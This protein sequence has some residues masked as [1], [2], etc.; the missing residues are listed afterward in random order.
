MSQNNE[1]LYSAEIQLR[2]RYSETDQMGYCYYGNYAQYF[3][4]GRVE[5]L[6]EL[7]MSYKIVEEKGYMLPVSSYN[8]KYISPAYYDDLLTITTK[9]ID[10]K[11]VRL[12]F[13]YDIT[14]EKGQLVSTADTT[15]VFVDK[16]TMRPTTPPEDFVSLIFSKK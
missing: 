12:Y 1:F 5:A 7:G 4:V 13:S 14:N 16:K 9:I 11:G 6:R 8:V 10:L 15:L 3:E 2:V